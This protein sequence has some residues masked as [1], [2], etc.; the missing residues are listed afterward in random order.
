MT[1]DSD[2]PIRICALYCF[3]KVA[4][5]TDMRERLLALCEE[6]GIRGT[7][8]IAREGV[9]GTVAATDDAIDTLLGELK[10]VLDFAR[11]EVKFARA[12]EIPFHR[13]KVR[14]K[15]EIV[16]MGVEDLDP[17]HGAGTHLSPTEWNALLAD[18]D[19]VVIDT[20]NDY[21][22]ALGT[23]DKAIDPS[24]ATF[25]EFPEWAARH[26]NELRG[27]KLAMFCTGGIRCEKATAYMKALGHDEVYHLKGGILAYLEEVPEKES[28]WNGDC[29]VFDERVAVG[30][31]LAPSDATLCRACR[32]PL[33]PEER[34]GAAYEEGVSCPHCIELRTEA[35]RARYR[36]RQR[37][38]ELA[39]KNGRKHL[40]G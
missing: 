14:L 22:I 39:Q 24:T 37:Q 18:P 8:L 29:F 38:M 36:Q 13:L 11:A 35:D 30:H 15:K 10:T 33:T 9:N 27:K 19:T 17:V 21:E 3:T 25:R 40:G 23:F 4:N 20:R 2:L 5:A 28:H 1:N 12:S 32:H 16:T 26:D 6:H 7:L 31:G 34:D